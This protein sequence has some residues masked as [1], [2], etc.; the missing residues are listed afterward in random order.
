M[1]RECPSKQAC[2]ITNNK[3]ECKNPCTTFQPC[4]QNAE[5]KVYDSL[6]LR[7]MTCTCIE[8]FTGKGDEL[9]QKISKLIFLKTKSLNANVLCTYYGTLKSFC[10]IFQFFST[11]AAPIEA[12]CSS[13]DECP[14]FQACISRSCVNP[15]TVNNPCSSSAR[16]SVTNHRAMCTCPPGTTGDPYTSCAPSN[17]F[18]T[19]FYA[20]IYICSIF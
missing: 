7:T 12:G 10:H 3:G 6:P 2:I 16:C 14:S 13:D 8:G 17:F 20:W 4:V 11:K 18:E 9:C 5:C 1:D 15:C 19:C